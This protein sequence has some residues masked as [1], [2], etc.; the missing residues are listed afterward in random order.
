M[1]ISIA[2]LIEKKEA[3]EAAKK[4]QYDVETSAG[5]MTCKLPSRTLVMESLNLDD[6]DSYIVVN[7]VV[8]PDLKDAK[9]LKAF[10]CMEPTDLPDKLFE[11]GEVAAI[12]VKLMS[13]AGFRKNIRADIHET[14]KN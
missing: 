3:I 11:P 12:S 8:E 2:E 9:L 1:A 4:A 14:V 5:V 10:G 7:C 13:L 6:A